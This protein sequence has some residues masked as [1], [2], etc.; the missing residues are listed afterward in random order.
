MISSAAWARAAVRGVLRCMIPPA[1]ALLLAGCERLWE[2]REVTFSVQASRP[3][4]CIESALDS[5]FGAGAT[6]PNAQGTNYIVT[7]MPWEGYV[8]TR[9]TDDET[10]IELELTRWSRYSRQEETLVSLLARAQ[11]AVAESC[12]RDRGGE[13]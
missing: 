1:G 13:T 8:R 5:V 6:R 12:G 10:V 11:A 3:E 9:G 7:A 4:N 2:S